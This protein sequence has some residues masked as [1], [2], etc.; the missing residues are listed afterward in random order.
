MLPYLVPHLLLLKE[1]E[2]MWQR[3]HSK[4]SMTKYEHGNPRLKVE[5]VGVEDVVKLNSVLWA[6]IGSYPHECIFELA[7]VLVRMFVVIIVGRVDAAI[8]PLFRSH[9]CALIV[10][11]TS[12]TASCTAVPSLTNRK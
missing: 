9:Y 2:Y 12:Y 4:C 3:S 1:I 5:E 11:N 10:T 6:G 8:T 7:S